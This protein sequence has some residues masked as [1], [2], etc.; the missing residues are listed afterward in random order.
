M[1]RQ[2]R[3][4]FDSDTIRVYQAFNDTIADAALEAG[5]FVAP[6]FKMERMTW[7]KPSF[8]WTMYRS[9]WAGKDKDQSRILAVDISIE[10]FQWALDHSCPSGVE[11]GMSL[12]EWKSLKAVSPVRVQWDPERDLK[13]YPT[14][15]R[16]I[17][18]GL[19]GEAVHRYVG[20]WI[21]NIEDVTPFAHRVHDLVKAGE[22]NEALR[23]LP[24]ER[25]WHPTEM[26]AA[27]A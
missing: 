11:P 4:M 10:G 25:P 27:A 7:I 13:S 17:Q 18:I 8:L 1:Q 26:R 14:M 3:A 2:I 24:L 9:G 12:E 19:G 6:S 22:T 20:E 5:T 21:R 15:S 16:T 23:I